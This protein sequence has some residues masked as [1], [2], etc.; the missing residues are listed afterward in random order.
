MATASA[1]M[2]E[3]SNILKSPVGYGG[4]KL[5]IEAN[6]AINQVGTWV[7]PMRSV[8]IMKRLGRDPV[9]TEAMVKERN[10]LKAMDR[11]TRNE[12]IKNNKGK[13]RQMT[14]EM[15]KEKAILTNPDNW[16][17]EDKVRAAFMNDKGE[18]S[19]TRIGAGIAGAYMSANLIGH[20]SL[21]I[22]FISN[23]SWN[24]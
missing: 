21:G 2:Q 11:D 18:Y 13:L 20:G 6:K 8:N 1:F 17:M 15:R 24:R 10:K 3:V 16:S 14:D 12:Y 5:K 9:H 22:P 23:A 7:D 4:P 19:K